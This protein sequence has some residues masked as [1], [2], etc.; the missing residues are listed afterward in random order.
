VPPRRH[1]A[2]HH[3]DDCPTPR[4]A[5]ATAS[6]E[7]PRRRRVRFGRAEDLTVTKSVAMQAQTPSGRSARSRA[8]WAPPRTSGLGRWRLGEPPLDVELGVNDE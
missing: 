6:N 1:T 8:P 7:R 5:I 3:Q 4:A 2:R